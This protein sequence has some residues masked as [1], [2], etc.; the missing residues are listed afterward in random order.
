MKISAR[1]VF[2]ALSLAVTL[3]AATSISGDW[4]VQMS[5]AGNDSQL[6]C[7]FTQ[8]DDDI[9]GK[10]TS[11]QG[12]LDVKGKVAGNN[13]SFSYQTEYNGMPLTVV[14][15]GT[16]DPDS[17]IKGTVNV[18]EFNVGGDFVATQSKK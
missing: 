4:K 5:I 14:Y 10:C 16:F 9:T 15:T 2:T 6:S 18:P 11:D 7:T 8:K 17:G 3:V 12:S 13:V 1:V